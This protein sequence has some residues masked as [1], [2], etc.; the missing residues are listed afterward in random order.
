MNEAAVP[1]TR[2]LKKKKILTC[3]DRVMLN[4][5]TRCC[6]VAMRDAMYEVCFMILFAHSIAG[7]MDINSYQY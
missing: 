3:S 4:I 2:S 1:W 5:L 6:F 7:S